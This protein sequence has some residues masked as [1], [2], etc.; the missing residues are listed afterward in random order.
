MNLEERPTIRAKVATRGE[1][2]QADGKV[3]AKEAVRIEKDIAIA[4]MTGR[5]NERKRKILGIRMK[6][7][8][9]KTLN[10]REM[11]SRK[12]DG[13]MIEVKWK[14]RLIWTYSNVPFMAKSE[15]G[16]LLWR[17]LRELTSAGQGSSALSISEVVAVAK[18]LKQHYNR[19]ESR[20]QLLEQTTWL[21]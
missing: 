11:R 13:N 17:G 21:P 8:G 15:I 14:S 9:T 2:V 10:G 20:R 3:R 16:M 19:E 7:S 1:A 18:S 5:A 6:S 4:A 12:G